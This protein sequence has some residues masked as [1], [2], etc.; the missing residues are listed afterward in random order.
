[1]PLSTFNLFKFSNIRRPEKV[2]TIEL[3]RGQIKLSTTKNG[4]ARAGIPLGHLY[5]TSSQRDDI[6]R[7]HNYYRRTVTSNAADLSLVTWDD[8][9]ARMA[10]YDARRLYGMETL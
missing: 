10:T 5:L 8:Q 3:S 7:R 4:N 1:M 2:D 9:L 6:L